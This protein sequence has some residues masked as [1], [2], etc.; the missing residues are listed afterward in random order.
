MRLRFFVKVDVSKVLPK[1]ITFSKGGKSFTVN[2]YYPWLPA[3]CKLCEKWGHNEGVCGSK[4]KGKKSRN[5]TPTIK[6]VGSVVLSPQSELKEK[7][8]EGSN[9]KA[10]DVV[11]VGLDKDEVHN[12]EKEGRVETTWSL[13]SPNKSGRNLFNSPQGKEVEISESKFSVLSIDES[14]EGEIV[15]EDKV[16]SVVVERKDIDDL[17]LHDEEFEE[18]IDQQVQEETKVGKRRGRKPKP[19]DDN[20]GKSTRPVRRKH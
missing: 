4:G 15:V 6:K 17:E 11:E 5:G 14:E 2:F 7:G 8:F 1:E 9:S 13:V 10:T 18:D 12:E 16:G 3:R 19:Q 20:P